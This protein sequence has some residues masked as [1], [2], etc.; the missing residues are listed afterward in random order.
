[1]TYPPQPGQPYGQQPD[2]YGQG[3]GGGYPQSGGFPQQGGGY[4]Q[5]G[6]YPQ[7]GGYP[8]DGGYQ[9]GG[10]PQ[11]GYPGQDGGYQQ[12]YPQTGAYPQQGYQD[13][14]Q[15][16]GGFGGPPPPKKKKTGLWIGLSGGAVVVIA[17]LITGF[18]APGFLLGDD[19]GDKEAGASPE[20]TTN[21][22]VSALNAKDK[23]ALNALKCPDAERRVQSAID[24][25]D[26][27][28][29]AKLAGAGTKVSETEYTA[30][31]DVVTKK[32]NGQVKGTLAKQGEK[33]CWKNMTNAGSAGGKQDK[34]SAER[35]SRTSKSSEESSSKP[36]SSSSGNGPSEGNPASIALAQDVVAKLNA[37]DK[38]GV[39]AM[40]CE[41]AMDAR[42][43]I[44]KVTSA[45]APA[46][47]AADTVDASDFVDISGTIDGKEASGFISVMA[48]ENPP[49][50]FN[51]FVIGF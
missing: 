13:P 30:L 33:W 20:D 34:P 46:L 23:N 9:Q 37:K 1:M 26:A 12:Q 41:N 29:S 14:N 11:Q 21:S 31:V 48:D 24:D 36:S 28:E 8:Q 4:P 45:S 15:Y 39:E 19:G 16:G 44:E 50:V 25:I 51:I 5:Q 22:L 40:M 10:Y 17:F 43:A 38:A 32:D 27:V 3:Q 7:Q 18:L 2:P 47:A 35:P 49:C 42:D 6:N